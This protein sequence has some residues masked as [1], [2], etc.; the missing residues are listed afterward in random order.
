MSSEQTMETTVGELQERLADLEQDI[1]ALG[2]AA[3]TVAQQRLHESSERAASFCQQQ[4]EK[5][6]QIGRSVEDS[7]RSQPLRAVLVAAGAGFVLG[8]L[9]MRR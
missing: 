6:E 7:V 1:R 2:G 9:W 5:A 4:R 3:R 8:A